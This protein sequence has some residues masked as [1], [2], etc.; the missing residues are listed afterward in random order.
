MGMM[1][2][3]FLKYFSLQLARMQG[4]GRSSDLFNFLVWLS[5]YSRNLL[6]CILVP[7]SNFGRVTI[8]V[9]SSS[10]TVRPYILIPRLA[11]Q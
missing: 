1:I 2:G 4:Y 9:R 3:L 6:R 7:P 8:R 10:R 11:F 5:I